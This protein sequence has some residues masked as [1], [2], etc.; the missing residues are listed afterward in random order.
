MLRSLY[1]RGKSPRYLFYMSLVWSQSFS[2]QCGEEKNLA[3]AGNRTLALQLISVATPTELSW[4]CLPFLSVSHI[5]RIRG[6]IQ[7]GRERDQFQGLDEFTRFQ[8]P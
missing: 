1:P 2:E 6:K 7:C 5:C 4:L 8:N 3:P